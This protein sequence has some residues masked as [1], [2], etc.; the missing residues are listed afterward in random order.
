MKLPTEDRTLKSKLEF[1]A[2]IATLLGGFTAEKLIFGDNTTGASNDLKVASDIARSMITRYGMS[3]KLG[4]IVF[5][6]RE[7]MVFLGKELGHQRNYSEEIAQ[8]IDE[9][10]HHLIDKGL[11]KAKDVLTEKRDILEKIAKTLLEK[12]TIEQKEFNEIIK[13]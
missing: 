7:E 6:E 5:G 3:E 11:K 8:K 1:E 2:E 13:Q 10:V 12:E 9:E 4:P